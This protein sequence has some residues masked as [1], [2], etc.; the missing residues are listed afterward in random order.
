[1]S[2]LPTLGNGGPE[3]SRRWLFTISNLA[4]I[5]SRSRRW[6][7]QMR[8][9]GIITP[10]YTVGELQF[11]WSAINR[12]LIMQILQTALGENS[13][14]PAR[15]VRE[16]GGRIDQLPDGYWMDQDL[17]VQEAILDGIHASVFPPEL[18]QSRR[19]MSARFAQDAKRLAE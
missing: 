1:M 13:P 2:Q 9:A 14:I 19:E 6:I 3:V 12:L 10:R 18:W 16:I 8:T 15:I 11:P 17:Q 7:E 5:T 4:Q